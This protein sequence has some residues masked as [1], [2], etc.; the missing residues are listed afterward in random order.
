M[1]KKPHKRRIDLIGNGLVKVRAR[2]SDLPC[3]TGHLGPKLH[4]SGTPVKSNYLFH[5]FMG[6][7]ILNQIKLYEISRI[8]ME[9]S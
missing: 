6:T 3:M 2:N 1:G 8:R 7:K 5:L 4:I 9:R